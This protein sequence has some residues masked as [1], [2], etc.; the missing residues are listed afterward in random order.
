MVKTMNELSNLGQ[1]LNRA[2]MQ[3][4]MAGSWTSCNCQINDAIA[5]KV[6][7]SEDISP[8]E[9]CDAHAGGTTPECS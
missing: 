6:T 8:Q 3:K 2:E 1:I 7:C 9:C 4:V 5:F